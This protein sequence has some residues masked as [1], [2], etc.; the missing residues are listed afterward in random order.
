M[1]RVATS[2]GAVR[3]DP[4]AEDHHHLV[5]RALRRLAD[6]DAAVDHAGVL[7]AARRRASRPTAPR[8]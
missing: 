2:G 3:Y 4:R 1:R 5:C 6:V 7:A 8:S